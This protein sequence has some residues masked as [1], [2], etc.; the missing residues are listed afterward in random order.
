MN[1]RVV[2]VGPEEEENLSLRYLTAALE[3]AGFVA[4]IL[5]F[6][7]GD[8]L[9]RVLGA[10]VDR[11]AP[12]ILVG[13]SLAFQWRAKD[14]LALVM[15]L[16]DR[17]YA[18]H[19]TAGGHFGTF[20]AEDLLADF[21]ELDSICRHEAEA[22]IVELAR[23]VDA[24]GPFEHIAGLAV[25]DGGSVVMNPVR[26][27]QDLAALA[28]PD[29]R[30]EP[31]VC[32]GH[33]M[34]PLVGSRGCHADC[35][36]CCIAAWHALAD[37]GPRFRT[38]PVADIADEMAWLKR[39]RGIDIFVFHDDNFF[40]PGHQRS[41][42]RIDALAD[43]LDARD[44]GPIATVVKARP[45]DVT[46]EVFTALRDRLGCI[47]VFLGIENA[48][49]QGLRTLRRRVAEH[50]NH[51][52]LRILDELGIYVC[53]NMLIFEPD[54]TMEGLETNLKFMERYGDNPL[55]F[56]RVELYAGTTLLARMQ[57]EGRCRGDYFGWDYDLASPEMQRVFR[58]A[59]SCFYPRNF[60]GDALANRLQT[61]RFDVEVARHFHPDVHDEAWLVEAKRLSRQLARDSAA[62]LREIVEF[63]TRSLSQKQCGTGFQPVRFQ[64]I[65]I[66]STP[67]RGAKPFVNELSQ[68]LRRTEREIGDA[69]GRLE[70]T[71]QT[72][73]GRRCRH[74]RPLEMAAA[75]P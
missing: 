12:P 7:S 75:S 70:E 24:G 22:T 74:A 28:W 44:L 42:D 41:L 45:T 64:G 38:R 30:G 34:A 66:G 3:R 4:C 17:G 2:L 49:A 1:G 35:A 16:R 56:G 48:S 21:P 43:A 67:V 25:R 73:V 9:P 20:A 36:F 55:N 31:P 32:L 13:V 19:I 57:A 53:F 27:P 71:I 62:A 47:R 46:A 6:N 60:A 40:L 39:E 69:A 26:R 63:V 23:A 33:R 58:L 10:V 59:M 50:E 15:A 5:P 72:A 14:C 37:G 51:E 18:G 65:G 61:T 52:A 11:R 29:R 54:A 8:D 68:R